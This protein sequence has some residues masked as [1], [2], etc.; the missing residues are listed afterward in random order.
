[1]VIQ[2]Q[3][4]FQGQWIT[5]LCPKEH[6]VERVGDSFPLFPRYVLLTPLPQHHQGGKKVSYPYI[7]YLYMNCL[8][9]CRV[10]VQIKIT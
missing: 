7:W 2:M 9:E 8:F 6:G 3:T 10:V 4:G 5:L 1:M